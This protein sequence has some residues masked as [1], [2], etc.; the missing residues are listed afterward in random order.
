MTPKNPLMYRISLLATALALT[1]IVIGAYTRL[2]DAGLGCP[3]WPGCYGQLTAPKSDLSITAALDA[4]PGS[5]IEPIK[6][7]TEMFHRYLAGTLGILVALIALLAFRQPKENPRLIPSLLVGLIAFQALLGAWTV[8]LKLYPVVVMSHLLGGLTTLSFLC[9]LALEYQ[10]NGNLSL[11]NQQGKKLRFWAKFSLG[12]L[13]IQLMLGGWTSANYAALVCPDFPFCHGKLLPDL[14]FSAFNFLKVGLTGSPGEP[15]GLTGRITIHMW[16]RIGA[17][18]TFITLGI[19]S[20]HLFKAP[21]QNLKNLG[22]LI[23]ALLTIQV[24]LGILTVTKAQPLPIAVTHNAIGATLL[25]SVIVVVHRLT[26]AKQNF[27]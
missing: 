7:E 5:I 3:D 27:L 18:V 10:S 1:V 15:L 13:F 21:R 23:A 19:L 9:W 14:D 26:R 24:S 8:T 12:V 17:V 6:A 11:P 20:Y 25:L 4:Y 2:T 22:G 16:H